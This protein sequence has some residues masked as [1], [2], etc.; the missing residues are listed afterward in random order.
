MR[1]AAG[2]GP[3]QRLW[4]RSPGAARRAPL[5]AIART[6]ATARSD[7]GIVGKDSVLLVT[8]I[9]ELPGRIDASFIGALAGEHAAGA[10]AGTADLVGVAESAAARRGGCDRRDGEG[11]QPH[12]KHT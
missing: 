6:T 3:R 5:L 10:A 8:L 2:R 7:V 12:S 9:E 1:T 4:S 11:E